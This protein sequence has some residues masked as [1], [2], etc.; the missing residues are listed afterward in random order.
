RRG[1]CARH[2]SCLRHVRVLLQRRTQRRSLF[3]SHGLRRGAFQTLLP[4]HAR[5]RRVF[6]ALGFRGRLSIGGAY[7]GRHRRN[8]GGRGARLRIALKMRS[9]AWF[10][11]ALLLAG[12]V[13]ALLAY[14]AYLFTSGFASWAFHRVA[15]RVAMLVLIVELVW[16]CRH[17]RLRKQQDFGYGLPW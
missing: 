11:A 3:E 12:L 13:G 16:L 10:V 7:R 1:R 5:R 9:F 17:L 14:P 6:R 15:G 8:R 4:R 2:Q